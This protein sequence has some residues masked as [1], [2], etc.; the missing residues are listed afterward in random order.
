MMYLAAPCGTRQYLSDKFLNPSGAL[1]AS[2]QQV[3]RHARVGARFAGMQGRH[4]LSAR[5]HPDW[6]N[7]GETNLDAAVFFSNHGHETA[8][9][10]SMRFVMNKFSV[11]IL[12]AAMLTAGA[13]AYADDDGV[14]AGVNVLGVG[15]GVHADSSGIGTGAHVGPVGAGV[16]AGDQGVGANT[17]VGTAD[18][19][20]GIATHRCVSYDRHDDGTRYCSR[21]ED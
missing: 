19:G 20:A 4:H 13:A 15:A 2:F 16:G 1:R 12:A 7:P 10:E 18:A 14:H 8:A 21:Y 3:H 5:S 9:V 11:A 17:H 6:G